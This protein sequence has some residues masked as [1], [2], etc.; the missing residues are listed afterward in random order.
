MK[1]KDYLKGLRIKNNLTQSDMAEILNISLATVKKIESGSTEYPSSKVLKSL[2]NYLNK[3]QVEILQELH[4]EKK[5]LKQYED[6]GGEYIDLLQKY[7]SLM[8]IE[9]WNINEYLPIKKMNEGNNEYFGAELSSRRVPS[10]NLIVDT[11]AKYISESMKINDSNVSRGLLSDLL[12]TLTQI[13]CKVKAY[14]I[15]FDANKYNDVEIYKNTKK[16]FIRNVKVKIKFVLF[17][18]LRCEVVDEKDMCES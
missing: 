14:Y 11:A 2:S 10:Y 16:I 18:G 17:D 13:S 12:L 9:G 7:I 8:S 5:D 1:F 4:F 6:N 15:L 3:N